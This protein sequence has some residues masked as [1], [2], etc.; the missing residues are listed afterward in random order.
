MEDLRAQLHLNAT[1]LRGIKDKHYIPSEERLA[2]F[3]ED[4]QATQSEKLAWLKKAFV[5]FGEASRMAEAVRRSL[6][7]R[8][9]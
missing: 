1:S 4:A 5:D 7:L 8:A 6:E 9:R 3:E 2:L